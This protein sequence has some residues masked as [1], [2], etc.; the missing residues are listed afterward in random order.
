MARA[1]TGAGIVR[2]DVSVRARVVRRL[3]ARLR[4]L[5][6]AFGTARI[7]IVVALIGEAF[8]VAMLVRVVVRN[9]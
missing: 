8:C 3:D 5:R 9:W 4:F 2:E 6:F 7:A 1:A